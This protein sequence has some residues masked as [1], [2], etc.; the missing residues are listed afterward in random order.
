MQSDAFPFYDFVAAALNAIY[1]LIYGAFTQLFLLLATIAEL[2]VSPFADAARSFG[3]FLLSP[4]LSAFWP[5]LLT[6]TNRIGNVLLSAINWIFPQLEDYLGQLLLWLDSILPTALAL[7]Y[8]MFALIM[9][10]WRAADVFFP[11]AFILA[12]MTTALVTCGMLTLARY[13]WKCIPGIG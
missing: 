6:L 2:I 12:T 8:S 11:V 4:F 7:D 1:S 3:A 5:I 10:F 13:V 9:S